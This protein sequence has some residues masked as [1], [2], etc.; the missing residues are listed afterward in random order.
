MFERN[1]GAWCCLTVRQYNKFFCPPTTSSVFPFPTSHIPST[2]RQTASSRP[3]LPSSSSNRLRLASVTL[4]PRRLVYR[5][6]LNELLFPRSH[7]LI[8]MVRANP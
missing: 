5:V 7:F 4:R 1:Q 2:F 3:H 8:F 6:D